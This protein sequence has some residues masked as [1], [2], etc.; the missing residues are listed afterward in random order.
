MFS[1]FNTEIISLMPNILASLLANVQ[2]ILVSSLSIV[3]FPLSIFV[4]SFGF[5]YVLRSRICVIGH[6]SYR[7]LFA[8]ELF[9]PPSFLVVNSRAVTSLAFCADGISLVSGSED[10][11]IRIWDTRTRNIVRMFRHAK[12]NVTYHRQPV[13]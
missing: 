2:L 4:L 10:G 1:I 7:C 6:H 8:F 5:I 12:G 9:F 13:H 11:K 3:V